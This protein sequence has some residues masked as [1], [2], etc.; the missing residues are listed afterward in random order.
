MTDLLSQYLVPFATIT[1]VAMAATEYLTI[2]IVGKPA[3]ALGKTF[4]EKNGTRKPISSFIYSAALGGLALYADFLSMPG[5][6]WG[7]Q[8]AGIVVVAFASTATAWGLVRAKKK[9]AG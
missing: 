4:L 5:E 6:G 8:A 3:N 9:A 1:A 2:P 7:K